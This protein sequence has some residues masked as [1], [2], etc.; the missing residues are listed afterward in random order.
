LA[1]PPTPSDQTDPLLIGGL[2][3]PFG[4]S[5]MATPRNGGE[6]ELLARIARSWAAPQSPDIIVHMI[7]EG[8]CELQAALKALSLTGAA[9]T[10]GG[11][12]HADLASLVFEGSD[13]KV[14]I[15]TDNME[16]FRKRLGRDDLTPSAQLPFAGRA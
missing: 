2:I 15:L 8:D 4:W 7:F 9:R 1:F 12:S 13:R 3:A 6:V 14:F 5:I 10:L 11:D 16:F